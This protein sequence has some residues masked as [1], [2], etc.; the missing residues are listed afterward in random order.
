MTKPLKPASSSPSRFRPSSCW[1]CCRSWDVHMSLLDRVGHAHTDAFGCCV[2]TEP[3]N[4]PSDTPSLA[5]DVVESA[6]DDLGSGSERDGVDW[7][8]RAPGQWGR[9]RRVHPRRLSGGG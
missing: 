8:A 3:A 7:S 4:A 9:G 1:P 6:L 5:A 2:T